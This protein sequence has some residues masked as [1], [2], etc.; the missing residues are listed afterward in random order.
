[1]PLLPGTRLGPYEIV[2]PLGSGSM[3]EVYQARD[4]RL[5][6]HVAIKVLP[7]TLSRDGERRE[8]FWR[9]ARAAAQVTH[10]NACRLYDIAEERER[11]MLVMEFVEGHKLS[12]R[13]AQGPIS[14]RESA[15]VI[16]GILSALEAFHRVGIV[17]RD[18][19][20]DNI[21]LSPSGPKIVDFG[22]AKY[23][24]PE[25]PDTTATRGAATIPGEFLGTPRYASPEQFRGE[26]IDLR[27]DIFSVGAILFEMLSGRAA[28]G[29]ATFADVAHSVLHVQPPALVG[30]PAIAA[31]GRIVHT[32]MARSRE[33]RYKSAD[34]MAEDVRASLLM[35]GLDTKARAQALQRLIA[36]PFR[37]L[38]PSEEI[39]FL[40]HSLPEAISVS[41][42]GLDNVLVR[43]SL[44][45]AQYAQDVLDVQKIGR[46]AEVDAILTGALLPVGEQLRL[47]AQLVEVPS[48][49][50]LWSHS[51]QTTVKELL[52]LHDD[53]VRRVLEALVPSLSVSEH[54]ALQQDRPA[55][56]TAYRLYLEANEA[57]RDWEKLPRAIETYE[58]CVELDPNYAPGWARLGRARW[59]WDKYTKGSREGLRSADDAFQKAF[60][61]NPDLPLAHH[62]Y[63]HL[64]VD[65]GRTLEALKRLLRCTR[66]RRNDPQLFAGLGHVCR[67][68]GLLQPALVAHREARRLDPQI[69]TTVNHTHFMLG[70]Y[71][72]ALEF[73]KA[74]F[75]YAT[76][77]CLAILGRREEAIDALQDFESAKVWR[78][79]WLYLQSLR[80]LL[81]G[82]REESLQACEEFRAATFRDPEG[83][84]YIAR[85]LSYLGADVHAM[86]LLRRSVEHGFY[87]Y[88]ALVRDPWLDPLRGKAEFSNVLHEAHQLHLEALQAFLAA[89]GDTLLGVG[90][91]AAGGA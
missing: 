2:L 42:A 77:L 8:R 78:L 27:A 90:V 61:L 26:P 4:A 69:A 32:A 72:H 79:G 82:K 65:Q 21:L 10:P 18:L 17:H 37:L 23:I 47:T 75:G 30:S 19:K 73:S 35:E 13:I 7:E 24:R 85:Q 68:C 83:M 80:T 46:E 89:G 67:Y 34:K 1:M 5:E 76:A 9:E 58:R 51:S 70:D 39:G 20:P 81:E 74:D 66:A 53:L 64:Q 60:Q 59:L 22:I 41:L 25:S 88:P 45:A 48:G 14:V 62:L 49:T 52:Q 31:M 40:C 33:D 36:L 56:P 11:L 57:G 63:T 28:F 84:Y 86:E 43:S 16:L 6:R 91:E 12:D 87:C 44:A 3:G 50:L 54:A 29:G 55:S 15:Q 71:Q 38:R